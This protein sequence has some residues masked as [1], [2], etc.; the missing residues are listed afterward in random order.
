MKKYILLDFDDTLLATNSHVLDVYNRATTDKLEQK[1]FIAEFAWDNLARHKNL[2]REIIYAI[3]EDP[4]AIPPVRNAI[5]FFSMLLEKQKQGEVQLIILSK[6]FGKNIIKGYFKKWIL[7]NSLDDVLYC[8]VNK[9]EDK[10]NFI[11]K[12]K[13]KS[14]HCDIFILD[15]RIDVIEPASKYCKKCFIQTR[16][17]NDGILRLPNV[18][19]YTDFSDEDLKYI[20][21]KMFKDEV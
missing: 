6:R 14:A 8:L 9:N 11:K 10:I 16:A 18:K 2:W 12:L 17:W 3:L 4:N 1:D 20:M 21:S 15:D 5:A 13:S 19:Y 7:D